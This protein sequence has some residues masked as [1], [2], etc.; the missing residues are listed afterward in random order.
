[1][2]RS[3]RSAACLA[4]LI[5]G[6][7]AAVSAVGFWKYAHY[8]YQGMDLAIYTNVLASL[9]NGDGW[10]SSIQGGSYLGDHVEPILLAIAPLFRLW[11]DARLLIVLQALALGLT[12]VP[13]WYLFNAS[14]GL[15]LRGRSRSNPGHRMIRSAYWTGLRSLSRAKSRDL[16]RSAPRNDNNGDVRNASENVMVGIRSGSPV[17]QRAFFLAALWLLNPLLWNAALFEFHAL[18][19]APVL[20]LTAAYFFQQRR[21]WR[22]S[23]FAVLSLAVREDIALIIVMFGVVA[24]I[25]RLQERRRGQILTFNIRHSTFWIGVPLLFGLLWFLIATRIAAAHSASGG[26]KFAIYYGWLAHASPLDV[27]RHLLSIGSIDMVLGL[28]LPF[29]FLPFLR[30]RWLLLAVPPLAQILLAAPGGSS[31]IIETHYALLFL[32]AF[33]LASIE[34]MGS[35]KTVS[36]TLGVK[37]LTPFSLWLQRQFPLPQSFAITLGVAT[38]LA[39]AW[40]L[41]PFRGIGEIA[42][43]GAS[44]DD[45]ARAT[46]YDALL[47]R[48]PSDAPIAAGYASLPHVAAR[49][50]AYA[51]P[52]AYL[53]VNQYAFA[54]YALPADLDFV[55]LDQRDA[56]AYAVQFPGVGWA[57]SHARSGPD[58]LRALVRDRG[59]AVAAERDGIALLSRTSPE[60]RGTA[61]DLDMKSS[62]FVEWQDLDSRYLAPIEPVRGRLTIDGLRDVTVSAP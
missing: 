26:Y 1:M 35:W 62:G 8:R 23:L 60:S 45:R 37:Y 34:A 5:I 20:V 44:S 17:T 50:G 19:F 47:S 51:L 13:V 54:P 39:V 14:T 52:Y 29:L 32:P 22:F 48:V 24:F 28:L 58:R 10:Y 46:A 43:R 33:V 27:L 41:G 16:A 49:A 57:A 42:A 30:P 59:F 40:M 15:S 2:R 56:I 12:A 55:L 38:Y 11:P 61:R 9:T 4:V 21:F 18:A 6:F 3:P 36:G 25:N 53:G 31:I 7:T